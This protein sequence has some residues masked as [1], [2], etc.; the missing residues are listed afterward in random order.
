VHLK[1]Q[2]DTEILAFVSIADVDVIAPWVYGREGQ[3]ARGLAPLGQTDT[4]GTPQSTKMTKR[5]CPPNPSPGI[6]VLCG[7][8]PSSQRSVLDQAAA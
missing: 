3:H 8:I 6:V 2:R 4:A 1:T 7:P 5:L